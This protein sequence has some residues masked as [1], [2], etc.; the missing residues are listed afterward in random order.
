MSV[1]MLKMM[2]AEARINLSHYNARGQLLEGE[3]TILDQR[4]EETELEALDHVCHH[5]WQEMHTCRE[6]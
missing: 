6:G 2:F 4:D 3:A 5:T 1:R